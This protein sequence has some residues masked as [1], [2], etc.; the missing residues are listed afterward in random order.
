[1]G[2]RNSNRGGLPTVSGDKIDK[3]NISC[4]DL[5]HLEQLRKPSI[6]SV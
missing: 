1:V 5:S 2:S 4:H 3:G 6:I